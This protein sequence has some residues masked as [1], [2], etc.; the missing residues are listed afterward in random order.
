[1][2]LLIRKCFFIN[3]KVSINSTELKSKNETFNKGTYFEVT[4]NTKQKISQFWKKNNCS[5]I[6]EEQLAKNFRVLIYFE[7]VF[8]CFLS[9]KKYLIVSFS[10]NDTLK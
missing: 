7:S 4:R 5:I 2:A 6:I 3:F 1:M 10:V 9:H 8:L